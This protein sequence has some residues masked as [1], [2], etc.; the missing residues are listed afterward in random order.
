MPKLENLNIHYSTTL[1]INTFI[2]NYDNP[3]Y[4]LTQQEAMNVIEACQSGN[5]NIITNSFIY[6]VKQN[7][8]KQ[9]ADLQNI[10]T[11][12]LILPFVSG[13]HSLRYHYEKNTPTNWN[14]T[15]SRHNI[16][17]LVNTI[18]TQIQTQTNQPIFLLTP[19]KHKIAS[20]MIKDSTINNMF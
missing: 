7:M 5:I 15:T 3:K 11:P 13:D 14:K 20:L 19:Q 6:C 8:I 4:S 2:S 12:N 1:D 9:T 18:H 16:H 10:S 17:T